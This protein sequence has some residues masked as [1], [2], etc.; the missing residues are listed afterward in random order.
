MNLFQIL[1]CSDVGTCCGNYAMVGVLDIGRKIIGLI[2]LL[3]P[4]V[5][6][7]ASI[8]QLV[9]MVVNPDDKK[10][11]KKITN[12]LIAAVVIF[13]IPIVFDISLGILP[14]DFSFSACW[15]TAKSMNEVSKASKM[16]YVAL[17]ETPASSI[18]IDQDEY[19][20]GVEKPASGSSGSSGTSGVAGVGAQRM[21]N[22]A[23]AELGNNDGDGSHMKY[24]NYSG[25]SSGDP[26][27]AAF[28]TW[29]AG[30]A[31]YID[32]LIPRF[33]ACYFPEPFSEKGATIHYESDH[34]Y[35]PVA[36]DLIFFDW[37]CDGSKDHVGIVVSSDAN[38]VYTV[39]GNTS[40]EGE[41]ASRCSGSSG[42]VSK[43]TRT[44]DCSIYGYATPKYPTS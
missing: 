20:K 1:S 39:E 13:F 29:V 30:Q 15:N 6:M 8:F 37:G 4:I 14:E 41:A 42:C 25:L 22:T 9:M 24:E 12:K 11:I 7:S 2:Q 21:V 19:E 40:G 35:N 36:G 44:R 34:N 26:W 38:N 31:G 28:V 27:C 33:T 10:S 17:S 32:T 43:R 23:L 18:F 3:A 5:L 16:R